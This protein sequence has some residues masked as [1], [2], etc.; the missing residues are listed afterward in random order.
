M[1]IPEQHAVDPHGKLRFALTCRFIRPEMMTSEAERQHTM[2]KGS[3]PPG[4]E[5]YDYHGDIHATAV[6]HAAQNPLSEITKLQN[7]VK[8]Q[9]LTGE[10]DEHQARESFERFLA[11]LAH[12]KTTVE[13]PDEE[14][15]DVA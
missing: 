11:S 6:Q 1:L 10:I 7:L 2:V 13:K 14:M 3:L 5:Q 15:K 12:S 9:I 4:S 8:A